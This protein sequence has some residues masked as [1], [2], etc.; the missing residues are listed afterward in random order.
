MSLKLQKEA[1]DLKLQYLQERD[2]LIQ[3]LKLDPVMQIGFHVLVGIAINILMLFSYFLLSKKS[4]LWASKLTKV[5]RTDKVR[6]LVRPAKQK[7]IDQPWKVRIYQMPHANALC[8]PATGHILLP[9][10]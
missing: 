5:L 7:L 2:N 3:E 10:V 8:F 4:K 9:R 6:S 1:L